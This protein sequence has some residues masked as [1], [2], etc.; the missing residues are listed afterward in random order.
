MIYLNLFALILLILDAVLSQ[1][2]PKTDSLLFIVFFVDFAEPRFKSRFKKIIDIFATLYICIH[3]C[4]KN[5]RL[6]YIFSSR[7]L[8][9][10]WTFGWIKEHEAY[11]T[12]M[13]F[14]VFLLQKFNDNW[15]FLDSGSRIKFPLSTYE[16]FRAIPSISCE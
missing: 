16:K 14:N 12:L 11:L 7:W 3:F 10:F 8:R 13:A 1:D 9:H 2:F 5:F 6:S 4:T 15:I